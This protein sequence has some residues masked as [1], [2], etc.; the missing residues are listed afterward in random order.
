MHVQDCCKSLNPGIKPRD[1]AWNHTFNC[2]F[3]QHC[4]FLFGKCLETNHLKDYTTKVNQLNF[5]GSEG[6][7]HF[8]TFWNNR[9]KIG[10]VHSPNSLIFFCVR[11]MDIWDLCTLPKFNVCNWKGT[12]PIGKDR[13][14]TIIFQGR[15][16]KLQGCIFKKVK[17]KYMPARIS[18]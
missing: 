16:V 13:F 9:K 4:Q 8:E 18:T 15:Y 6:K 7:K 17:W 5:E 10:E 12:F 1:I 11:K 3:F 2:S 14:P